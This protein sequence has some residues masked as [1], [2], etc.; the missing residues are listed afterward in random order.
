MFFWDPPPFRIPVDSAVLALLLAESQCTS[1]GMSKSQMMGWHVKRHWR[2]LLLI[3]GDG[4]QG[5]DENEYKHD[6]PDCGEYEDEPE[7][8]NGHEGEYGD[9]DETANPDE[10]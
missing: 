2:L 4:D 5:R 9:I 3:D 6:H 1:R 7:H 10:E 8:E